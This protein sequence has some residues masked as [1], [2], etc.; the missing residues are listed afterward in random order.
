MNRNTGD[1]YWRLLENFAKN[2]ISP[3]SLQL[4]LPI[5][6]SQKKKGG[7]I[8]LRISQPMYSV[9]KKKRTK[10]DQLKVDE[11]LANNTPHLQN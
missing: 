5:F 8:L 1:K 3:Q 7:F 11:S 6:E 2:E 10:Q 9:N 4:F